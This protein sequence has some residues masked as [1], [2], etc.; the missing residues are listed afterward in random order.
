MV[1]PRS[2]FDEY[3]RRLHY[4]NFIVDGLGKPT[5]SRIV[6]A[7]FSADRNKNMTWASIQ[8][9]GKNAD[10]FVPDQLTDTPGAVLHLHGHGLT[11]LKDNPV[12]TPLL[13]KHGLHCICPHGQR[14]WWL[15]RVCTEF[16]PQISPMDY[17]QQHVVPWIAEEWKI[18]PPAIA[19]S[20]ISMGGQ[21]AL[22]LA[23]RDARTFP[24]VVAISP[25]IDFNTWYGN[26]LPLDEMFEDAE[27]ARQ[28]TATLQIHPLN[29]PRS[30]FLLCDPIDA[31]WIESCERLASKLY[32]SGILF[33]QDFETSHGGHS[34]DYF[35]HVAPS[36]IEFIAESL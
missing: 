33:K 24:V 26:G 10:V 16:D 1:Q 30:Q 25:A 20:G 22:Q 8:I 12:Y 13:Q 27:D 14:S 2:F 7:F 11:T 4:A 35:E 5:E 32:S 34:W 19:L 9:A 18:E 31:D 23:Y 3:D 15:D 28:A 6:A 17:L 36:V 29:W 21:G